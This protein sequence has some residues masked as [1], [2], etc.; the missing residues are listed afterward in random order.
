MKFLTKRQILALHSAL[1]AQSDGIDTLRDEGLLDSAIHAP[2][3]T[4]GGTSLYPTLLE[5]AARLGYG[6]IRNHPFSDGNKRIG[7]H[8]MLV[9]LDVNGVELFY[10]DDDLIRTILRVAS[11]D[12]KNEELLQWLKA[13][14]AE[15]GGV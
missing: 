2:L 11:G 15:S 7:A 1:A 12:M 3:Q 14:I 4:F 5:K 9:T 8:A 6:L 13:H 10:E